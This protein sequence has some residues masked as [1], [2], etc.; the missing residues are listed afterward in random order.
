MYT[1][2]EHAGRTWEVRFQGSR[3]RYGN[4]PTQILVDF[5][6]GPHV[7]P[8]VIHDGGARGISDDDLKFAVEVALIAHVLKGSEKPLTV[9]DIS[10]LTDLP[11]RRVRG[12]LR[13]M[14]NDRVDEVFPPTDPPSYTYR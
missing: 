10:E 11:E 5:A 8:G 4:Q 2:F 6:C 1:V 3:I 13:A 7:Y 9:D 14:L 12:R